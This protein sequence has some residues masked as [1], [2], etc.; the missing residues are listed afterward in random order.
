MTPASDRQ[1]NMV[2]LVSPKSPHH[3]LDCVEILLSRINIFA[4]QVQSPA[5]Q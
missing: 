2:G 1:G 4:L 5:S 3:V